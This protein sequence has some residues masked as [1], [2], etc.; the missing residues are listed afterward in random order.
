[1]KVEFMMKNTVPLVSIGLPVYNGE[2]Y[3]KNSIDTILNQTFK[4]IELI[5]CDN[6]SNDRTREICLKY[7][8]EDPR[9][10]YYRNERNMGATYNFNRAFFLSKGKYFKWAAHDDLLGE[11]FIQKCVDIL[12]NNNDIVLCYSKVK[13]ID[14]KGCEI[15]RYDFNIRASSL[16][17]TQRF[18]D[19][20]CI[21]HNCISVFGLIRSDILRLTPKIEDY[22]GSDRCLLVKLCLFGRLYEIPEYLFFRREH[23]ETSL[24]TYSYQELLAWYNPSLK[25]K[26]NFPEWRLLYELFK[27]VY[28]SILSSNERL[29]CYSYLIKYS[30]KKWKLF[31]FDLVVVISELMLTTKAGAIYHERLKKLMKKY[32]FSFWDWIDE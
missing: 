25:G 23:E 30:I 6:A 15:G 21:N 5:I 32:N 2:N 14:Q 31:F 3:I 13:K 16:S 4:D 1:M 17:T 22:V 29:I 11:D 7:L 19:F 18:H 12:E 24:N 8:E 26:I 9:I 10:C 28:N 20:V 27:T